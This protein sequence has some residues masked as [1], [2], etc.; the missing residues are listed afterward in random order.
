M[1]PENRFLGAFSSQVWAL[2]KDRDCSP[3]LGTCSNVLPPLWWKIFFLISNWHFPQSDLHLLSLFLSLYTSEEGPALSSLHRPIR[4]VVRVIRSSL[5]FLFCRLK[6]V[7]PCTSCAP[8]PDHL[9][10]LHWTH[11]SMSVSLYWRVQNS[12]VTSTG[13]YICYTA[14]ALHMHTCIS[15]ERESRKAKILCIPK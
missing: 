5:S 4:W 9:L 13:Y 10:A 7:S 15:R 2:F 3:S 14:H 1:P 6:N 12:Q 11:Y 8:V